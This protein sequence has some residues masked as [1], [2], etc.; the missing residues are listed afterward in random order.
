MVDEVA[1]I[2]SAAIPAGKVF[3]LELE[4]SIS[5]NEGPTTSKK[6]KSGERYGRK[7]NADSTIDLL[8]EQV[9]QQKNLIEKIGDC[10][11]IMKENTAA[12]KKQ[13]DAT[14][15]LAVLAEKFFNYLN[16]E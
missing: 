4:E 5:F 6:E 10:Y 16:S 1:N 13:A 3:G 12:V 8:R 14:E 15:K 2:R 9:T 11:E 7:R